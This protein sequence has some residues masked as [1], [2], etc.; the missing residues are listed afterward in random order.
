MSFTSGA[1]ED[2]AS[3]HGIAQSH[4]CTFAHIALPRLNRRISLVKPLK[5]VVRPRKFTE[6][7][8][9]KEEE[10]D[11]SRTDMLPHL[12]TTLDLSKEV[13]IVLFLHRTHDA[14]A[15]L[16]SETRTQLSRHYSLRS[17]INFTSV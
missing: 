16:I 17:I 4:L 15:P 7:S 5:I 2:V 13:H 12:M 8:A 6:N 11:A 3:S 10:S 9:G 14:A 1:N